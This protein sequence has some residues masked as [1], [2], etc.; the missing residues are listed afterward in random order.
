[1]GTGTFGRVRK[2]EFDAKKPGTEKI[3]TNYPFALKMLKK[4]EVIRLKQVDHIM[5]ERSILSSIEHP[6]IVNLFCCFQDKARLYMLLEFVNGGE[7]F[8]HLRTRTF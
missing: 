5:A 3:L 8:T 4:S 7:L 6:F 1:M 2:V